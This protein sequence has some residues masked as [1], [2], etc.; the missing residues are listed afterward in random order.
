[1]QSVKVVKSTV[2]RR[3]CKTRNYKNTVLRYMYKF[4]F[5]ELDYIGGG[6]GGRGGIPGGSGGII[7]GYG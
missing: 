6:G 2:M 1:M 7:V 3:E 5:F 4:I